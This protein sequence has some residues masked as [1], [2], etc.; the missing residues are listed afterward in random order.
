MIHAKPATAKRYYYKC[1]DCLSVATHESVQ[2]NH[3]L[4]CD[5]G[6]RMPMMGHVHRF[7]VVNVELHTPCDERCTNASGPSCDCACGGVNHGSGHL[8][9]LVRDVGGIPTLKA[10]NMERASEYRAARDAA[11][12]RIAKRHA[13]VIDAK[14]R[15]QY[16]TAGYWEWQQDVSDLNHAC[17]L[18]NHKNRLAKLAEVCK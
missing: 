6:G 8:V 17:G 9:E 3:D 18:K 10:G 1:R 5:C 15:G 7:R 12:E 4:K 2:P 13:Y 11:R 16:V 14:A